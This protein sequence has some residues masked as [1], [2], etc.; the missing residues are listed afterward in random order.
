[1][2]SNGGMQNRMCTIHQYMVL[3]KTLRPC[4]F[5]KSSL[6]IGRVNCLPLNNYHPLPAFFKIPNDHHAHIFTHTSFLIKF[7][8]VLG[9]YAPT[10][11]SLYSHFHKIYLSKL[12]FNKSY[13]MAKVGKNVVSLSPGLS[14]S[15]C[16]L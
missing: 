2:N 4:L 6:V 12:Y 14:R 9:R 11:L 13:L 8:Q 7:W 15:S 16:H 5:D 10:S 1:M 3:Q